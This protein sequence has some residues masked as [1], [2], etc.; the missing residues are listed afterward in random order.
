MK[1]LAAE[2]GWSLV[3][4][5]SVLIGEAL[6]TRDLNKAKVNAVLKKAR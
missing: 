6:R 5:A 1:I 3:E 2:K 4:T